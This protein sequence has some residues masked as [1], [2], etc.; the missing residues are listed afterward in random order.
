MMLSMA[1]VEPLGL[2]DPGLW[3]VISG[4]LREGDA[5]RLLGPAD[6]QPGATSPSTS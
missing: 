3:L 4:R 5:D 2:S 1:S 6:A